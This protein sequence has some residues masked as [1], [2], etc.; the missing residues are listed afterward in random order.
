MNHEKITS[1]NLFEVTNCFVVCFLSLN[2]YLIFLCNI[3][4]I[5]EISATYLLF[6]TYTGFGRRAVMTVSP[7]RLSWKES[8]SIQICLFLATQLRARRGAAGEMA[9]DKNCLFTRQITMYDGKTE[10]HH[11]SSGDQILFFLILL[12]YVQLKIRITNTEV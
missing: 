6:R 4:R 9:T 1:I 8:V 11:V 2:N 5:K 7:E 10:Q 12:C 3:P